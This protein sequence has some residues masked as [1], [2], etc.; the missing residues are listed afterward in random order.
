VRPSNCVVR[1]M[2]TDLYELTMAYGYWK[3]GKDKDKAVFDLFFRENP[4]GGEFTIFAGLEEVIRSV[5]SFRFTEADIK[6]LRDGTVHQK[7]DLQLLFEAGL[8]NG[9][10][11]ETSNGFEELG[12]DPWGAERWEPT[13]YPSDDLRVPG[14][15]RHCESAFFDWLK[16]ADCSE[17]KIYAIPEGTIVFP[18]IPLIRVEGPL[19]IAQMQETAFLNLTG[20]PSLIATNAA[21][22]RLAA[23]QGKGLIEF[24]LRRAQGPDG[25]LSASRY[26]YIGGFDATSNVL[27]GQLFGLPIKGTMA[28]SYITAFSGL[29][30]VANPCLA[31]PDGKEHDFVDLVLQYRHRLGYNQTNNGELAAFISYAQAFPEAFLALVDTYDTLKSGVS[32]FI[33]VALALIHIG[34]KPIGIRLDSGDLAYF[35]KE[36]RKLFRRISEKFSIE[37]FGGLAIVASN[38]IDESI[39]FSLGQQGHEVDVFG[40]GTHLVTCRAQPALGCVYKL[41]AINGQP[42]IKLSN[43][44]DKMTIPGR[45]EAYRLIGENRRPLIDLMIEAGK[46]APRIGERILC[47]HPFSEAKRAYV[48]PKNVIPLHKCVWEGRQ[49][50]AF[51]SLDTIREYVTNQISVMRPD[52]VRAINPTPYKVSVSEDLYRSM[53]EIWM[54]EAPIAEIS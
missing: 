24:G 3:N 49:T 25:A 15:L 22:F 14:P 12:F 5:D 46:P 37:S 45:K 31:G 41:V 47:R 38:D 10:V 20:F 44:A 26:S 52:H 32:N 39:L 43:E 35:S 29:E 51:P 2:L 36:A 30:E 54:Q 42:R 21:R 53:R 23:G 11:M 50:F 19:A 4:F 1:P 9:F 40:I 17:L 48:V 33:C 27:A 6:Y 28:H 34:R 13:E 16:G 18:R 7:Q 8:K